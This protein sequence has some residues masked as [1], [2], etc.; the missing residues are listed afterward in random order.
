M[1]KIPLSK[2]MYQ[3]K[4][5]IIKKDIENVKD[6]YIRNKYNNI[7]DKL[8]KT[9]QLEEKEKEKSDKNNNKEIQEEGYPIKYIK[10][11]LSNKKYNNS[12]N[13]NS[14]EK[15]FIGHTGWRNEIMKNV[16]PGP[17]EY[18]PDTQSISKKNKNLISSNLLKGNQIP[19]D[20]KLFTD[21]IKD[22]IPPVGTY[23]PQAFDSIEFKNQSKNLKITEIPIKDGFQK[24]FKAKTKKR[25]EEK[26][27]YEKIAN[28][29][30]SPCSYFNYYNSI[31]QN[32][33]NKNYNS[34]KR[35]KNKIYNNNK[36]VKQINEGDYRN[37]INSYEPNMWIKKTFNASFV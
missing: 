29:M 2:T 10:N 22:T 5:E 35:N 15:R 33:E 27:L 11:I 6:V 3:L 16:N 26:K 30:L 32:L 23:Q 25:I 31:D 17:G 7:I 24:I 19:K 1:K 36:E 28:S 12:I 18:E 34:N 13:F 20:R 4:N 21:E 37:Y 9:K 14:K 8:I